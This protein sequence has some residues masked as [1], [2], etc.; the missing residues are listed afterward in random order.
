M[1]LSGVIP[2]V[3]VRDTA[4]DVQHGV[5]RGTPL[6]LVTTRRAKRYTSRFGHITACQEVHLSVWSQHG[7]PRGTPLGLVTTRH[8]KR[9]T[10]RFGHIK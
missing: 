4:F 1:V 2:Q 9:Y 10:S 6:G 7:V 5:P 8:A 3:R